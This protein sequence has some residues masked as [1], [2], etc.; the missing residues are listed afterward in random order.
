MPSAQ[1]W[2]GPLTIEFDTVRFQQTLAVEMERRTPQQTGALRA[3]NRIFA[4]G[5][6]S[7]KIANKMP[8][9]LAQHEGAEYKAGV[10]WW[11]RHGAKR[12]RHVRTKAYRTTGHQWVPKGLDVASALIGVRWAEG[13]PP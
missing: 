2:D 1:G 8:Y 6:A 5:N 10:S 3:A 12:V 11:Q 9:A 13:S 4:L 7:F